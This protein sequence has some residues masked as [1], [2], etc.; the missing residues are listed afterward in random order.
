MHTN[1]T[2]PEAR[3]SDSS[4]SLAAAAQAGRL[5]PLPLP[6]QVWF[7]TYFAAL[8]AISPYLPLYSRRLG[9][10]EQQIGVV[11]ALRPWVSFP[12]ASLWSGLADKHRCHCFV[13]V[14]NFAAAT[15][16][17]LSLAVA[18]GFGWL[19]LAVLV[20]EFFAGAVTIL[21]DAAVQ[22]S[23]TEVG[24]WCGQVEFVFW[25]RRALVF[26]GGEDG[27]LS[28][29]ASI[30]N[31]INTLLLQEGSYGRQRLFGAV[32][33]GIFAAVTGAVVSHTSIYSIFVLHALLSL[34]AA[35]PTAQLDFRPLLSK[36]GGPGGAAPRGSGGSPLKKHNSEVIHLDD[37]DGAAGDKAGLD[38][39]EEGG[40][41]QPADEPAAAAAA[42][43]QPAVRFWAG[44]GQ[45]LGSPD[46]LVFFA[47]ALVLGY[48]VGNIETFLF[49]YLDRLHGSATLMGLSLTV[50]CLAEGVV[51]YFSGEIIRGIGVQKCLHI[52]FAAFLVRLGCYA[53]LASWGNPWLVGVQGVGTVSGAEL[54]ISLQLPRHPVQ[55]VLLG[56]AGAS[57]SRL[58]RLPFRLAAA[59]AARGGAARA[60]LWP[61]VGSGHSVLG[62]DRA[63]GAG[64]LGAV[65][66]PGPLLWGRLWRRRAGGWAGVCVARRARRVCGGLCGGLSRVGGYVPDAA[67]AAPGQAAAA[68]QPGPDD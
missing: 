56:A 54:G 15:L 28:S 29:K 27:V 14:G 4:G 19:L 34:L 6:P 21:A 38:L 53:T 9:L 2:S 11:G 61:G 16:L 52:V 30:V 62:P 43:P 10:T 45:L 49:L 3:P 31:R 37:D 59:G 33:W 26:I 41:R 48:G 24:G 22:A 47:Q 36:L 50:T 42:P 57:D 5:A 20:T 35:V 7:L 12:T 1:P 39:E 60:D 67:G 8:S 17:R 23:C 44:V 63:T 51:F 13:F 64:G 46:A 66:L 25:D 18:G 65:A 58:T 32:G 68:V 40:Q 55:V